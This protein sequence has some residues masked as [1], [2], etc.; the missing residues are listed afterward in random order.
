MSARAVMVMRCQIERAQ[1]ILDGAGGRT[2]SWLA[3]LTDVPC[4]MWFRTGSEVVVSDRVRRPNMRIVIVPTDTD[5]TAAD[6]VRS[7]VDRRAGTIFEGP[8]MI[9]SVGRRQD[10]IELMLTDD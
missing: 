8:A 2:Q 9:D 5:V 1:T 7:I 4:R 6:R 3:H 10:H